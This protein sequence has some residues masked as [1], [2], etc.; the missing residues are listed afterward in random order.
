MHLS[1]WDFGFQPERKI[2]YSVNDRE[3]AEADSEFQGE[4]LII[5]YVRRRPLYLFSWSHKRYFELD[6]VLDGKGSVKG[7]ADT[8]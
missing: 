4:R 3:P 6:L 1:L 5:A 8:A 2:S 7:K